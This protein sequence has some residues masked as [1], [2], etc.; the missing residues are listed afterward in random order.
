LPDS[1]IA[2]LA[3][4]ARRRGDQWFVGVIND[5]TPRRETVSLNFLGQGNYKLVELADDPER[6]D[7]FVRTERAVTRK[8]SLV[9][10]LRR[11]GGYVAWLVPVSAAA[12]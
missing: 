6:N 11:D 2:Q 12:K 8:D 7:A 5:T 1:R 10:P 4:F 3:A 9:L